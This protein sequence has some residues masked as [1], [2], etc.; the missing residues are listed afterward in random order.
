MKTRLGLAV[1]VLAVLALDQASKFA[2]SSQMALGQSV[3]VASGLL[4]MTL[5]HN[6]GMALGI[7]SGQTIPYKTVLVTLLS[8][9]ALSA[10]G[11]YALRTPARQTL[12]RLGLAFVLGGAVGNI[13]DRV[14]LGYVVD[15]I[16]VFYR[17]SHWPAFNL[18]DTAICTGVGL[19]LLDTLMHSEP[20]KAISQPSA[21]ES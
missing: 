20:K 5:V 2:V 10:V 12:T 4:H 21:R 11:I 9:A 18:A 16:D 17:G 3:P 14:R 1:I 7:L 19:L 8:L 15:F 13:V 6:T